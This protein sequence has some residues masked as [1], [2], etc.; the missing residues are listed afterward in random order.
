MFSAAIVGP[1]REVAGCVDRMQALERGLA[2]VDELLRAAEMRLSDL[3]ALAVGVGPGGFSGLRIALSYA[4]ALAVAAH[5]PLAGIASY[6]TVEPPGIATPSVA[7]VSGRQGLVCARLRLDE[8]LAPAAPWCGPIDAVCEAL[9]GAL[10]AAPTRVSCCGDSGGVAA[11]LGERG[12]TVRA[13]PMPSP[14][15]LAIAKLAACRPP[16][17]FGSP[18]LVVADYGFAGAAQGEATSP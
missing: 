7:A 18:H 13:I 11:R 16:S 8:R 6:D 12:F 1:D 3:D 9:A 10:G 15:A 2:L 5:L 14:P 4:K 17:A